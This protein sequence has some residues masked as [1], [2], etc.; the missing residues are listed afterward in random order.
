MHTPN[1]GGVSHVAR[2][3]R[4]RPAMSPADHCSRTAEPERKSYVLDSL[5]PDAKHVLYAPDLLEPVRHEQHQGRLVISE[6]LCVQP[7]EARLLGPPD[8]S[9]K[10]ASCNA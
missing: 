7:L 3:K 5:S 4:N 8:A 2:P 1:A 9:L 10:E 6:H